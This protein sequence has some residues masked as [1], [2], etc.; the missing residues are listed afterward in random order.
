MSDRSIY[1]EFAAVAEELSFTAAATRLNMAQPWLSA[2]IR[3]LEKRLGYALFTRTTSRV[4]LTEQGK[5]LLP[6]AQSISRSIQEFHAVTRALADAPTPL[7]LGAPVYTGRIQ[8]ARKLLDAIRA[9]RP[10]ISVDIDV[11]WN[12]SLMGKLAEGTLDAVLTL[13]PEE[14]GEFERL[15]LAQ[16]TLDVEMDADDPLAEAPLTPAALAGRKIKVFSRE[17]YADLYDKLFAPLREHGATL[18]E[19]KAMWSLNPQEPQDLPSLVGASS[20]LWARPPRPGRVRRRVEGMP[21]TVPFCILRRRE[22]PARSL[23]IL[24]KLG[25]S[26]A[27][28]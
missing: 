14:T 7:R 26:I 16:T 10:A 15:V 11:A 18:V 9:H 2:R 4:E 21:E 28:I 27:E 22:R 8:L 1:E 20:A 25:R 24:W 17:A 6:I 3:Q 19:T 12:P 13:S 5:T 23:E